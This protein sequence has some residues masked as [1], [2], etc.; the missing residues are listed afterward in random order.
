MRQTRRVPFAVLF[1]FL[2]GL[3]LF[4]AR[5]ALANPW[6]WDD[7]HLIRVYSN[8]ELAR[9][10]VGT[11][12]VD[13]VETPG[14]RPGTTLF[15]HV[16]AGMLGENVL[17]HRIFIIG[18]F[19]LAVTLWCG[20]AMQLGASMPAVALAGVITIAAQNNWYQL[21]W[22]SDGV[23]NIVMVYLG[24]AAL[25]VTSYVRSPRFWK[26]FLCVGAATIAL[27]T[28]EESLP[29]LVV[30][31]CIAL[32]ALC[33]PLIPNRLSR[34]NLSA[35]WEQR[36]RTIDRPLRGILRLAIVL[37]V[38]V[39]V[40]FFLRTLFVPWLPKSI[41][42]RGWGKL[43]YWTLYPMGLPKDAGNDQRIYLMWTFS[44]GILTMGWFTLRDRLTQQRALFWFA[45]AIVAA[46]PGIAISSRPNI[47]F[48]PILFFSFA[49]ALLLFGWATRSRGA[50]VAVIALSCFILLA[51]ANHNLIAQQVAHPRSLFYLFT[52][53]DL[54]YSPNAKKVVIPNARRAE[55][56]A[57]LAQANIH[58]AQ[59][60]ATVYPQLS[61]Q[62]KEAK[63]YAPTMDGQFFIP[64]IGFWQP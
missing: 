35:A 8:Q 7:Y 2:L 14:Y 43:V 28:R 60:F 55:L 61:S 1:F 62:A 31:P 33:E 12:D 17:A 59:E 15:N 26:L 47:I 57:L 63:R 24:I 37:L 3:G 32:Y 38:V 27:F 53:Y 64:R 19:A 46:T 22:I 56:G 11:W 36:D 20:V 51:S 40:Y 16:R 48:F 4:L 50:R 44:L 25:L 34:A 6:F 58:S 39:V 13:G 45:C 42:V 52:A 30:V 54:M 29:I 41:D 23:H 21:V 18:L 49:L 9:V 5:D 10:F